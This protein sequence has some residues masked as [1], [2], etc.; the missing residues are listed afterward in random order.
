MEVAQ[1]AHHATIYASSRYA[2]PLPSARLK[3]YDKLSMHKSYPSHD[4]ARGNSCVEM[5]V[6]VID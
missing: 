4:S 6:A 5:Q 2:Y 1:V 3:Q